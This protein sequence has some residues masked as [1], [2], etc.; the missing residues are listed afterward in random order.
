MSYK[1][2]EDLPKYKRDWVRQKRLSIPVPTPT[3]QPTP[4]LTQQATRPSNEDRLLVAR[5]AMAGV[6]SRTF[7]PKDI[8]W[9]QGLKRIETTTREIDADGVIIPELT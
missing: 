2:I 6:E 1:S 5:Q 4:R 7:I 8:V 9:Y 3:V